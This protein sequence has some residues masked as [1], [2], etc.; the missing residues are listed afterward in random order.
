MKEVVNLLSDI[1]NLLQEGIDILSRSERTQETSATAAEMDKKKSPSVSLVDIGM[2][3]VDIGMAM[4]GWDEDDHRE[5]L[6]TEFEANNITDP[7]GNTL[8]PSVWAWC[9]GLFDL[10]LSKAGLKKVGSLAAKDF[11][12]PTKKIEK[13]YRGCGASWKNHIAIFVGYASKAK[14]SQLPTP[15]KVE[16]LGQWQMVECGEDDPDA[17]AMVLGGN[18]SD[19]V[20]ISP[21][22]FFNQYSK[23]NGY[24]DIA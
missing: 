5:Q 13:P 17:I 14:L 22:Y 11:W 21:I 6:M 9:A 2:A 24:F 12:D 10:L 18:Q 16:S 4:L 8:D 20:N 23:F 19:M 1:K 15:F 3:L 7:S